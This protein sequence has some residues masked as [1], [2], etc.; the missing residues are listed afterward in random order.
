MGITETVVKV[1]K[2]DQCDKCYWPKKIWQALIDLY[3]E[4]VGIRNNFSRILAECLVY[5]C[6]TIEEYMEEGDNNCEFS[7]TVPQDGR[8]PGLANF[9][10]EREEEGNLSLEEYVDKHQMQPY[11]DYDPTS[12]D[13]IIRMVDGTLTIK[14]WKV[15]AYVEDFCT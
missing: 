10:D 1:I 4:R 12:Y 5:D 14:E 7:W 9:A 8:E 15:T 13:F 6:D 2:F 3:I 11:Q